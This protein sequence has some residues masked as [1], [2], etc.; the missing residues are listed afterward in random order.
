MAPRGTTV[1]AVCTPGTPPAPIP[2]LKPLGSA[3]PGHPAAG[4]PAVLPALP[5]LPCSWLRRSPSGPS[6]LSA[7]CCVLTVLP[8]VPCPMPICPPL[9]P[10]GLLAAASAIVMSTAAGGHPEGNDLAAVAPLVVGLLGEGE[11]EG[12]RDGERHRAVASGLLKR[13]RLAARTTAGSAL[14]AMGRAALIGWLGCCA[15]LPPGAPP[16]IHTWRGRTE[17]SVPL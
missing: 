6:S 12:D 2:P 3:P 16:L 17:A 14:A 11:R 10:P 9:P 15:L 7:A 1:A 8:P 4:I 13:T 5:G